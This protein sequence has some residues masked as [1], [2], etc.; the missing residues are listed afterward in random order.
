LYGVSPV[1]TYAIFVCMTSVL[2][3]FG[4]ILCCIGLNFKLSPNVYVQNEKAL[5]TRKSEYVYRL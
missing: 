4:E 1:F 3:E 2:G 5:T